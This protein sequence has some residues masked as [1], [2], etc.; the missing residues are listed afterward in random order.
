M[1][2]YWVL[3][4]ALVLALAPAFAVSQTINYGDVATRSFEL[5]DTL[6]L[7]VTVSGI[8]AHVHQ[9]Y[10]YPDDSLSG[11]VYCAPGAITHDANES[12][13]ASF[14]CVLLV[15]N[16][17]GDLYFKVQNIDFDA[18]GNPL[19]TAKTT[20]LSLSVVKRQVT[21]TNYGYTNIGGS[22]TVGQ[23]KVEVDDAD[24]V[25][26]DITVYKGAV[27]VYSGVVFIGQEIKP[28]SDITIVFNGYSQK[29]GEAFFT[30]KTT[31]PVSVA[32]SVQKYYV[33]APSTVYAVGDTNSSKIDVV[34]NCP[35][36]SVCD[37]NGTC[38]TVSVPDSGKYAFTAKVGDYTVKCVGADK[39]VQVHVLR[40][41]VITK[42]VTKE[43]KQDPNT[44]CPSWF[45]SLPPNSK[46]TYCSSFAGSSNT[47]SFTGRSNNKYAQWLGLLILLAVV[48]YYVWKKYKDGGFGGGT[49]SFEETEK[50]VEA[51]PDIEG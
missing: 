42:T 20:R 8:P 49:K 44:I 32:S 10:V 39:S 37:A 29:R 25:S 1:K 41:V 21:Y 18:N 22:I 48:G 3:F 26:A 24:V 45:Y 7:S 6:A 51:V 17:S 12:W 5:N 34:T 50:E 47:T 4:A 9:V 38:N 27:P 23:Y 15:G 13:D 40:P 30:F 2:R 19:A 43:V 35:K 31:F 36:I 28:S 14:T 11:H 33:V 46:A 16:Y